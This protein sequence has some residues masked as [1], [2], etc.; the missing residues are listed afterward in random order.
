MTFKCKKKLG[1]ASGKKQMKELTFFLFLA[2]IRAGIS[3]ST[4]LGS[5]SIIN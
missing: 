3:S 5:I 2:V 4:L 1:G